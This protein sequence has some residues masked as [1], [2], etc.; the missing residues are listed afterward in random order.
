[1]IGR[2]ELITLLDGVAAAA[3]RQAHRAFWRRSSPCHSAR[4]GALPSTAKTHRAPGLA[5]GFFLQS[6]E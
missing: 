3:T 1:M 4:R 6:L 5:L 2:R